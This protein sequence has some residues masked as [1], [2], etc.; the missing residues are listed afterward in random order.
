MEKSKYEKKMKILITIYEKPE[1]GGAEVSTENLIKGMQ[2]LGNEVFV[3]SAFD[4]SK[5]T[6]TFKFKAFRTKVPIFYFQQIYLS[7]FIRKVVKENNIDLVHSQD[8]LTTPGAIVGAKKAGVPIVVN[9]RDYWFAC[10][11]SSCCTE[12][13]ELYDTYGFK[14]LIGEKIWRMPWNLYKMAELARIRKL[15]NKADVLIANSNCVKKKLHV[16]NIGAITYLESPSRV[17]VLPITRD[18]SEFINNEPR[19]IL[20][21]KYDDYKGTTL[22]FVGNLATNKGIMFLLDWM[23]EFLKSNP[24]MRFLIAGTGVL[25]PVVRKRVEGNPQ[26]KMLG[27]VPHDQM[28]SIYASTDFLLFPSIWEDPLPGVV[29]EAMAS[30]CVV[31]SFDRGGHIDLLDDLGNGVKIYR[32]ALDYSN[33]LWESYIK[34]ISG[35]PLYLKSMKEKA[36]Q[37]II[38]KYDLDE[39]IEKFE[40][41]YNEAIKNN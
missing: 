6:T 3:A 31:I 12:K 2:K 5:I 22:T 16:N 38:D 14:Q 25:E 39:T 15:L 30:G 35:H 8:R 17:K 26:I 27:K 34:I 29:L 24:D 28:K 37:T 9:F 23:P 20:H 1:F 33:K 7:N 10:P 21:E 18:L 40:D 41:V 32:D 19:N 4:W 13:G 36:R 11:N